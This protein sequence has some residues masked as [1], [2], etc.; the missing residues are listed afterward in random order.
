MASPIDDMIAVLNALMSADNNHRQKAE[1]YYNTQLTDNLMSALESLITILSTPAFELI[2]RSMAGILLRRAME[3]AT[4]TI[5][6]QK[7]QM[8]KGA[9]ISIWT[10]ETNAILLKRLAHILAQCAAETPWVELVP[11][12]ISHANLN[13]VRI[14]LLSSLNLIET[15]AEYCPDDIFSNLPLVGN[16]LATMICSPDEQ[17]QVACARSVGA[18]I[19]AMDDDAARNIFKPAVQ[20]II[21]I[22][23]GALARGDESDAVSIME[24]LVA[25][26][27]IQPIFFKGAIDNIVAAMITVARSESLEFPTRSLAVE[28]MVTFAETAPALAR[29]CPGLVAGLIPLSM[30][31]ALEVDDD[32]QDWVKG[33]YTEEPADENNCAGEEAI[34]RA[35]AGMGGRVVAQTVLTIVKEYAVRTEWQYRRAAIAGLSRLAEG[36]TDHFKQFLGQAV[37]LLAMALTDSSPRVKFEAIQTIGRFASLY[38]ASIGDLVATFL[39][40]LTSLLGNASTCDKVRGHAASAM[41]NLVNPDSCEAEALTGHLEPLLTALVVCL[42][43]AAIEVQ[44]HC[45][46]L[47]GCAAQVAEEAFVP[48]YSSFMPGIKAILRTATSADRSALRGKAMECAGLIGEAVGAEIFSGDALEIMQL[49]IEAIGVD[50]DTTFDYILPAC[51][52]I[53]KA[54]EIQ[55]EPFLPLVMSPLLVGATQE[56][57]FSM[58][59]AEEEDNEGEV[60]RDDDAGTESAVIS[61]GAGV[62][63]RVTLNTHAVQQKNQAARMLYEFASSMRGNLKAYLAPSAMACLTMVTDKHSA[64]IRSSALMALAKIFEAYVHAT[65]MGYVTA[66]DLSAM[67]ALCLGKLS[68]SLKGEINSTARACAGEALRDTLSACYLSGVEQE[69]GTFRD[70]LSRPEETV[71]FTLAKDILKR[72]VECLGRR[73]EKEAA[74]LKNE[75]LDADDKDAFSEEL[76]E[77][78]EL[79]ADLVDALGQLLKIFTTAFMTIFDTLVVPLFA[80]FLAEG[81]PVPLQIVAVCLIDDAIEFGGASCLK[82]V[83][84]ALG[85]FSRGMQSDQLVLRQSSVYGIAQ[86]ARVAPQILGPFLDTLVP[87]LVALVT[88]ASASEE[89]NEGVTDNGLFA[90]GVILSTPAY[91]AYTWGG[92][93]PTHVGPIWLQGL[94]LKAD[95]QEAKLAHAQLCSLAEKGDPSVVGE[96]YSNLPELMR[97]FSEALLTA[98]KETTNKGVNSISLL[99]P[100]TE[101]RMRALVR[102]Y[103]QGMERTQLE[104]VYGSLSPEQ[105]RA[106]Q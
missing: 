91:R 1:V 104:A 79:L 28:L 17:V 92:V 44:P 67:L 51:G 88:E 66:A 53:S 27:Q 81:Q 80:P 10:T 89:E 75:G 76:E 37:P 18:C 46:V 30:A 62:R 83:P 86:T 106:L 3:R 36:A 71:A 13:S 19:V 14:T 45:L 52:R 72:C 101:M 105:Q 41:I 50:D 38:P 55:F 49:L 40:P 21:N 102:Q 8:L 77:E 94:P 31:L 23:G 73:S 97:V 20:P 43:S 42:Q 54:L 60:I 82:Y 85:A 57:Q 64:D 96:G 65:Q 12:I 103:L 11:L 98:D 15:I 90:L 95:E 84:Q 2:V 7:L 16:F 63:K 70:Q 32:E 5:D 61:L 6:G 78:E 58:V 26:A 29:R 4:K 9:L 93:L 99:H 34:E 68:E 48:Y 100:V 39:P 74:F 47:L 87:R 24:S 35:A 69:D 56:I 59:D 33:K 22:L 25:V